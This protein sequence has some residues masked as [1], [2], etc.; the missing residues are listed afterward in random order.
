MRSIGSPSTLFRILDPLLI[1]AAGLASYWL[2]FD[3]LDLPP[4]HQVV[5]VAAFALAVVVFAGANRSGDRLDDRLRRNL[6]RVVIAWA[7]VFGALLALMFATRAGAAFSRQWFAVWALLALGALIAVRLVLVVVL[8]SLR[9]RGLLVRR[10]AVVGA[11]ELGRQVARQLGATP[12]AGLS[13]QGFFDDDPALVGKQF[14]GVPV[15]GAASEVVI[16]VRAGRVDQVWIA[17]PLRAEDRVREVL[18][19]L[20]PF[21]V[22]V[23]F[24]PDIFGFRLL[25][26]SIAEVGGLPVIKLTE[27]PLSGP[28]GMLKWLEDKV[29]ALAVLALVWPLLVA[30]AI[31]IKI[32]SPGPAIYRQQRG[33]LDNRKIT[34]WKFRTMYDHRAPT[35]HVPQATREDPRVTPFGALLRRTSLDELPQ[36]INVLMGDMSVVGPRP[37]ALAHNDFYQARIPN[38]LR[39][40][41]LKPG[42]TGWAQ[43]NGW[44]GET[45]EDWKMEVRVQHDLWYVENWSLA[46]DLYIILMTVFHMRG[47]RAY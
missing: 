42:I 33:G 16:D 3:D 21:N 1:V 35:G 4:W 36:F 34:V 44:R 26:H 5:I 6:I 15:R 8:Q 28:K 7:A 19:L 37:H 18:T 46:L 31:G 38:Y 14:E 12:S 32:S 43:I 20:D 27:N 13:I 45:D 39:R 25:N 2:R 9:R 47:E 22:E 40:T 30:I 29:I 23:S 11:G 17:L 24:V 41:W 10:V